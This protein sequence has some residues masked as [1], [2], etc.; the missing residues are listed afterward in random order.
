MEQI[1]RIDIPITV[2]DKTDT[3]SLEKLQRSL[4]QIFKSV[5]D[6]TSAGDAFKALEEGARAAHEALTD[7]SS[8]AEEAADAAEDVE[9]AGERIETIGDSASN[10]T[11]GVEEL[12]DAAREA[13]EDVEDLGDAAGDA[14]RAAGPAFDNAGQG[15]DRFGQRVERSQKTLRQMFAE[16]FQLTIAA[17]DKASPALKAISTTVK[18]LVGK[19]WNVVVKMA[20]FVTA[21]F[22][23][24]YDLITSPITMAISMA[25]IGLGASDFLSTFTEFKSG[26]SVVQALSGATGEDFD[27]LTAKAEELGATTQF[28]AA[29]AAEGM[30]YLAMAGWKTNDIIAAMPGLLSLAAAGGTEL[31]TAADIVSDVMTAMGM[32]SEEATRAADV[33]AKTATATNTSVEGLGETLKYAAPI[34]HSFGLSLEDVSAAAGLMANAGIKGSMAGTALR[35]SLLRMSSPTSEMEKTMKK[36]GISFTDSGGKMKGMSDIIKQLEGAFSGLSES[37]RLTAAQDLFGTEAA[38]AWLG[39]ISQG[40][41]AYDKL[42]DSLYNSA[43]A[44]DEMSQIRL[45]NLQGDMVKLQSAVDGMKISLMG[46][47]DPYLRQGVQ[48][49]TSK[50][51]EITE[52]LGSMLEGAI[53]KAKEF[54]ELVSGVFNSDEFQNADGFAEKFF[55]AWDKIVA[56]PFAEWWDGGGQEQILDTLSELGKTAGDLLQGIFTG[57]FAAIKGEDIDVEGMNL[58]G[59][60]AAGAEMAKSFLSSFL[61]G[62]DIGEVVGELPGLLAAGIFG[63]GGIDAVTGVIDTVSEVSDTIGTIGESIEN[64]TGL[65]GGFGEAAEGAA[66][67]SGILSVALG[68]LKSLVTAIPVWGWVA[69]AAIAAIGGGIYLYN[70]YLEEQKKQLWAL[71]DAVQES[72]EDFQGTAQE[73]NSTVQSLDDLN[74]ERHQIEFQLHVAE[75]GLTETQINGMKERIEEIDGTTAEL[76][77]EIEQRGNLTAEEALNVA[78]QLAQ[79]RTDEVYLLASIISVGGTEQDKQVF[80]LL[81]QYDLAQFDPDLRAS[82]EAEI[83]ALCDDPQKAEQVRQLLEAYSDPTLDPLERATVEAQIASTITGN[84]DPEA[85]LDLLKRYQD[86][87]LT[88]QTIDVEAELN[89]ICGDNPAAVALYLPLFQK[90]GEL[91]SN[92]ADIKATLDATGVS[93]DDLAAL[94]Q[95]SALIAERDTITL[96]IEAGGMTEEELAALETRYDTVLDKITEITGGAVNAREL[97]GAAIDANITRLESQLALEREIAMLRL[98]NNLLEA[99]TRMPEVVSNENTLREKAAQQQAEIASMEEMPTKV[100]QI[101]RDYLALENERIMARQMSTDA[102]Y[103]TYL[104]GENGYYARAGQLYRGFLTTALG[105]DEEGA[106]LDWNNSR[107]MIPY[108]EGIDTIWQGGF[109]QALTDYIAQNTAGI[110]TKKEELAA[111]QSEIDKYANVRYQQYEGYRTVGTS[112]AFKGT[113]FE[114]M[115][116]NDIAAQYSQFANNP[117]MVSAFEK[118]VSALDELNVRAM[119][120]GWM[121]EGEITTVDQINEIKDASFASA[122]TAAEEGGEGAPAKVNVE[123]AYATLSTQNQMSNHDTKFTRDLAANAKAYQEAMNSGDTQRANELLTERTSIIQNQETAIKNGIEGINQLNTDIAAKKAEIAQAQAEIEANSEKYETARTKVQEAQNAY[124]SGNSTADETLKSVN[125]QLDA[126][127]LEKIESINQLGDAMERINSAETS[128]KSVLTTLNE[129]LAGMEQSRI[130]LMV[131]ASNA[132]DSLTWNMNTLNS[133]VS[134]DDSLKI[135]QD[136]VSVIEGLQTSL[137]TAGA[138]AVGASGNFDSASTAAASLRTSVS[139]AAKELQSIQ[140]DYT[141]RVNYIFNKPQSLS[142]P[143]NAEGGIYDGAMV[144]VVAEDGPEAIIPLGAKRRDRGLELW[145]QA[146]RMLGVSEFAEGGIAAPYANILAKLPDESFEDGGGDNGS[147]FSGYSGNNSGGHTISISVDASPTY[148]INGSGT[149]DEIMA[150]L[151]EHQAELAELFGSAIAEQLEDIVSNMV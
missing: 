108:G 135:S 91:E 73:V 58:N 134:L 149:P 103:D 112:E 95:L 23:K 147:A 100:Q 118:A 87:Q 93:T 96:A 131:Q 89:A 129:E 77:I 74:R 136:N 115:S 105:Y 119:N 98:Q 133:D 4:Q 138:A 41:A 79:I 111:T 76:L 45:D 54:A 143:Q 62:F 113:E 21:P 107:G 101:E 124:N 38:S 44:A 81:Q 145:K 11:D 82:V 3:A 86:A 142:V 66:G 126:L 8:A 20:D 88:G 141:I 114:G 69:V 36:L 121:S 57:I 128:D 5:K 17:I 63:V 22:R 46:Q 110:A 1:F 144:S 130:D 52:M 53:N 78:N 65:F 122:P 37:E 106:M 116:L 94:E 7:V 132:L 123:Q 10:A 70:R 30:Q 43:G 24:V 19:A 16:K 39:I 13:A 9:N 68:G 85:V 47:L 117:M 104:N 75:T 99:E 61:E 32:G 92:E 120:E 34:A 55:I 56:E 102:E 14:G 72:R 6:G 90:Y 67:S 146:G 148:Q 125:E 49:I 80:D 97:E 15:V 33:F 42:A 139:E 31:G 26:M 64:I 50:V 71:G 29:Q 51:P 109:G 84:G 18:G 28:T 35:S 27:S 83:L 150:V 140:G 151:K 25:G 48:W 59:L 40:S 127:G 2:T 60:A 12:G 137:G